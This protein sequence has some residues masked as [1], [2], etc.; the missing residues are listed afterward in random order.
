MKNRVLFIGIQLNCTSDP[1]F[2]KHC[3]RGVFFDAFSLS[4]VR[5]KYVQVW[6]DFGRGVTCLREDG[7]VSVTL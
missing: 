7:Y 4:S 5:I 1:L 2:E 3:K 6:G